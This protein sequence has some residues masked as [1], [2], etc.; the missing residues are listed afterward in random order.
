MSV[1]KQNNIKKKC[2]FHL[3][4][5]QMISFVLQTQIYPVQIKFL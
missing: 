4:G 5:L 2:P 1:I 3:L